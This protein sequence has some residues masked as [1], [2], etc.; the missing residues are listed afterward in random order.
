MSLDVDTSKIHSIRIVHIGSAVQLLEVLYSDKPHSFE[1]IILPPWVDPVIIGD[2]IVKDEKLASNL[3]FQSGEFVI[4][5]ILLLE[6]ISERAL[7]IQRLERII[8]QF[9]KRYKEHLVDFQGYIEP[10]KEF[11]TNILLEFPKPDVQ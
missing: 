3:V 6:D 10:F 4:A 11:V 9:E 2:A 5:G 7:Y 1:N 8:E